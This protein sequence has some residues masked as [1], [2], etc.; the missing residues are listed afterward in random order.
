M[1]M[2][3]HF[4]V[5]PA[6]PDG[7]TSPDE[8]ELFKQWIYLTQVRASLSLPAYLQQP[9]V[10]FIFSSGSEESPTLIP[11]HTRLFLACMCARA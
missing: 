10:F 4:K 6:L 11:D 3:R 9:H 7:A 1:Q 2:E 5:P 8:T